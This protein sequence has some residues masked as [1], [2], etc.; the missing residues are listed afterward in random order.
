MEQLKESIDFSLKTDY[1][2]SVQGDDIVIYSNEALSTN[3]CLKIKQF[4]ETTF[5]Y[6]ATSDNMKSVSVDSDLSD[7]AAFLRRVIYK[8][9]LES[10]SYD[11][12]EKLLF[13]PEINNLPY[14]RKSYFLRRLNDLCIPP[15]NRRR[16]VALYMAFISLV[17]K[18]EKKCRD[19]M[20]FILQM[21]L[22]TTLSD[23]AKLLA[24]LELLNIKKQNLKNEGEYFLDMLSESFTSLYNGYADTFEFKEV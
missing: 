6:E 3:D 21:N 10:K 11:L 22:L 19:V 16:E 20:R 17:S 7:I 23:E 4:M 13:G 1:E 15:G 9:Q 8:N 2:I 12:F 24:V 5:N 18:N 14:D